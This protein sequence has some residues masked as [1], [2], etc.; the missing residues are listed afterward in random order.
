M[1]LNFFLRFENDDKDE[2]DRVRPVILAMYFSKGN[3]QGR[4]KTRFNHAP[5]CVKDF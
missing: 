5:S 4:G 3:D 1:C 2:N